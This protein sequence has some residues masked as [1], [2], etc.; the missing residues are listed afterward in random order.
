MSKEQRADKKAKK[1]IFK[2]AAAYIKRNR[3]NAAAIALVAVTA[4]II[5]VPPLINCAVNN[6]EMNCRTHI[7]EIK[8]ALADALRNEAET[9]GDYLQRTIEEGGGELSELLNGM[10]PDSDKFDASD[11]YFIRSGDKLEIRCEKHRQITGIEIILSS[12]PNLKTDFAEPDTY[13]KIALL[14]VKGPNKYKVGDV[15]D[16]S[17]RTKTVFE[18]DEINSLINNLTVT[19]HYTGGGEKKLERGDYTLTCEKIDMNKAGKY[20]LTVRAKSKSLWNSAAYARFMLEVLDE[21]DAP[22]LIVEERGEGKYEL[23]AWD[24]KDFVAEA[25]ESGNSE[26][27]GASIVRADG[28]YY[29]Y[30]DGFTIDTQKPNTDMF[31]YALDTDNKSKAAYSIEFDTSSII[32]DGDDTPHNGSVR[33]SNDKIYV[34]QEKPSKELSAGWIRV[35]CDVMKY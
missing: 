12:I 34:W 29:Y 35:Y 8:I 14:T 20:V 9:G 6:G 5:I 7:Y 11:Y 26:T 30:P 13:G 15:L 4:G 32:E 1:N 19:A 2:T 3:S 17:D 23:A 10:T 21:N 27:F 22:P 28:K 25:E 31:T 16:A 24:W 33:V 18:G